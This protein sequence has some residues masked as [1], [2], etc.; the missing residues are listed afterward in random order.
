M[1]NGQIEND[2]IPF[3]LPHF[4]KG[5]RQVF[6]LSWQKQILRSAHFAIAQIR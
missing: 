4:E 3:E 2:G 1:K 5:K 6:S